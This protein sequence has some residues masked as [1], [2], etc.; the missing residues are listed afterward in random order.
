MSSEEGGA[1]ARQRRLRR[2]MDSLGWLAQPQTRPTLTLTLPD[3]AGDDGREV[4]AARGLAARAGDRSLFAGVDLRLHVGDRVLLTGDNGA[5][6]TTL[7]RILAGLRDPDA[8]QVDRG[9]P[10]AL[11]P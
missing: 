1:T 5:G 11:L 6:K 9:A 4:L 2:Q 8:G 10:V 3:P 7:L